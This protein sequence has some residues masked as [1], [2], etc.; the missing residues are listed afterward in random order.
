MRLTSEGEIGRGTDLVILEPTKSHID[1]RSQADV[2][3]NLPVATCVSGE[4]GAGGL[5]RCWCLEFIKGVKIHE[6]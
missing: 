1:A 4:D 2:W 3:R 5:C 6:N